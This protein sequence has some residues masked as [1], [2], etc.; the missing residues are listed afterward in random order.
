MSQTFNGIN[1]IHNK[2]SQ[3]MKQIARQFLELTPT[4]WVGS[5][6]N[7]SEGVEAINPAEGRY[8]ENTRVSP[9]NVE[10]SKFFII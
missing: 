7:N 10:K 5:V 3:L 8:R 1:Y 6:F 2:D 9:S 4:N